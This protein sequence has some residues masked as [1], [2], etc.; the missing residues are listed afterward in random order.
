MKKVL[1]LILGHKPV[2]ASEKD[3]FGYEYIWQKVYCGRCGKRLN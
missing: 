1:C 2:M 3:M